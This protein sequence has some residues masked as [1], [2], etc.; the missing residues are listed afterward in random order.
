M[1]YPTRKFHLHPFYSD[2]VECDCAVGCTNHKLMIARFYEPF[3]WDE[4]ISHSWSFE[5]KRTYDTLQDRIENAFKFVFDHDKF[6]RNLDGVNLNDCQ[7]G[8]MHQ[9]LALEGEQEVDLI[10][11]K[12]YNKFRYLWD[13]DELQIFVK[14]GLLENGDDYVILYKVKRDQNLIVYPV[15]N[16]MEFKERLDWVKSFI[17][18]HEAYPFSHNEVMM[19]D[20]D[21]RKFKYVLRNVLKIMEVEKKEFK[22]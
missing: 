2:I 6:M 8:I 10:D 18:G 17:E 9:L 5:F 15:I 20:E 19:T 1:N 16:K 7:I 3:E 4:N 12:S 21:M 14:L 22:K 11:K 13:Y